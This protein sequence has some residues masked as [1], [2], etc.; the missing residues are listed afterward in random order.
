MFLGQHT[1]LTFLIRR[2]RG[3]RRGRKKKK[4][5][6]EEE[7]GRKKEGTI[8]QNYSYFSK[9][10]NHSDLADPFLLADGREV[11]LQTL[12]TLVDAAHSISLAL[13]PLADEAGLCGCVKR[14]RSRKRNHTQWGVRIC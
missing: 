11:F 13:V 10:I 7:G 6:A 2:K 12:V 3:G 5:K 8:K 1:I 14:Q 9:T 4:K